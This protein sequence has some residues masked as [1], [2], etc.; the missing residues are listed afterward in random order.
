MNGPLVAWLIMVVG[1]AV[2]GG[3]ACL[4]VLAHA[5]VDLLCWLCD[6]ARAAK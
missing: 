1:T 5:L 3:I 6:P 4:Y 2:V